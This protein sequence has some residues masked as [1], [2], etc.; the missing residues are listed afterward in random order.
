MHTRTLPGP[1]LAGLL[2]GW[3]PEFGR[4][5][6]F[7]EAPTAPEAVPLDSG[8]QGTCPEPALAGAP[9]C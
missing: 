4:P 9:P 3:L 5:A 1:G 7:T 2:A 8:S 6:S